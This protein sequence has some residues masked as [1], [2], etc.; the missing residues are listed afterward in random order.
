VVKFLCPLTISQENLEK[1]IN[2]LEES[3]REV[4]DKADSIP[5]EKDY[6]EGDY[7]VSEEVEKMARS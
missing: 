6:F 4:C 2:I 5:E 3:I 1:G 7:S